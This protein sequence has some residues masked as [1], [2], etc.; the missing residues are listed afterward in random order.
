MILR[1][2]AFHALICLGYS[3]HIQLVSWKTDSSCREFKS[4]YELLIVLCFHFS[5]SDIATKWKQDSY[6]FEN[7]KSLITQQIASDYFRQ[8]IKNNPSRWIHCTFR[9]WEK[10]TITMFDNKYLLLFHMSTESWFVTEMKWTRVYAL[11]LG[12]SMS[13]IWEM[14]SRRNENMIGEWMQMGDDFWSSYR[15]LRFI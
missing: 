3:R 4:N 6:F 8:T 7:E 15:K 5:K 10:N 12:N 2:S 9:I 13:R 14:T 11:H 1:V